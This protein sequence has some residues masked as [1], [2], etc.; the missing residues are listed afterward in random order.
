MLGKIDFT[1]ILFL[2]I[3]TVSGKAKFSELDERMQGLWHKKAKSRSVGLIPA[4]VEAGSEAE[5][6]AVHA[7]YER[8][9]IYAEFGKII[10]ISVGYLARDRETGRFTMRL[11]SYANDDE[12]IVL[13]EFAEL[14][15][16][17][18]NNPAVHF[19]CGH[20]IREFDIPYLCR[21]LLINRMPLPN[22]LNLHGKKPWETNY[23]LD[24]MSLWKFGDYKSPTALNL[25]TAVF[26]IPSPKDDI[27][28]SQVGPTY[29]VENDLPRISRYCQKDVLAVAQVLL[30]MEGMP[31]VEEEDV[32]FTEM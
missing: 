27:D 8:A 9:G 4:D 6:A 23:F 32:V 12:R 31:L 26:G 30:A 21:R 10:C 19:L 11:K 16:K 14:L 18:F 1:K 15:D 22:M 3:E 25:L 29:W 2:D 5:T 20:N 13:A 17:H 7:S 24:T 28:G